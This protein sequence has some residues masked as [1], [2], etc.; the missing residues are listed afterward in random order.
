VK[1]VEGT[2]AYK[3]IN[4]SLLNIPVPGCEGPKF[5]SD[6][7]YECLARTNTITAFKYGATAPMGK[8]TSDPEA[9]V[10]SEFR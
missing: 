4:A 6:E 5:K 2:E 9:V 7:Y 8:D 3:E 10:D 1:I